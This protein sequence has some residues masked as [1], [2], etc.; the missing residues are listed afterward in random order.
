MDYIK[1]EAT[2]RLGMSE[3]KP[4]KVVYIHVHKQS[5]TVQNHT[6]ETKAET[7]LVDMIL[8]FFKKD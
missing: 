5:Y 8:D 6:E 1:Q 3:P 2:E 7:S 4:Y